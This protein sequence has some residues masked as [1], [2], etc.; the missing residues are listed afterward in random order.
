MRI[1]KVSLRDF[2]GFAGPEDYV[3]DLTDGKNLLLY[4]ENGSGKSSLYEALRGLFELRQP[5]TFQGERANVFTDVEDGYVSVEFSD[6]NPSEYRWDYKESAPGPSGGDQF[7]DIAR[8]AVFLDYRALLKTHYIHRD[9]ENINV[10]DLLVETLLSDVDFGDGVPLASHWKSLQ[11]LREDP[12]D[13]DPPSPDWDAFEG[14]RAGAKKF[15]DKL[16]ALLHT[17]TE[18]QLCLEAETNRLLGVLAPGLSISLVVGEHLTP[19]GREPL[20]M[21]TRFQGRAVLLKARYGGYEPEHAA[22]FLNEARLTAIALALCLAAARLN[23]PPA[24]NGNTL[25]L[26]VL[27]DVLIGLD[28]AHR[29]PLLKL[30]ARDFADWQVFVFTHDFTW[31]EMARQQVGPEG[32]FICELYCEQRDAEVFE[33][34]VLRQGG[35]EGF[36][37]RARVHLKAG[38]R[39]AAAVY[40]RAAFEEKLRKFC[41]DKSVPLPFKSNPGQV[42]GD[43]FLSA[44]EKRLR[45]Q[46]LWPFF[47]PQF[48]RLR[49]LRKVILNP[50][51]HS[52][53]VNLVSPE[54]HEA[55]EA[56]NEFMLEPPEARPGEKVARAALAAALKAALANAAQRTGFDP[57]AITDADAEMAIDLLDELDFDST[58]LK[59]ALVEARELTADEDNDANK[60]RLAA[61]LRAAFEDSLHRFAFRKKLKVPI[62]KTPEA[63]TTQELW[64][65]AKEHAHLQG[66]NS[67]QFRQDVEALPARAILL[68]ELNPTGIRA[69]PFNDLK[70]VF[71]L[72]EATQPLIETKFQ[73]KLDVFTK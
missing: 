45:E 56:V 58:K 38:E 21:L 61:C 34:P 59:P 27:D 1:T 42:D 17:P 63:L 65:I 10:F 8:R 49:M 28:L 29:L 55:I 50:M 70:A 40:A 22:H 37:K 7:L 2:R 25:R 36:L 32:W 73:T 16:D 18:H 67:V 41:D 5:K 19:Q 44:A 13:D 12:P 53:L 3:F 24:A 60:L 23:R 48:H 20:E 51:S 52:N 15:R 9:A 69:V 43:A 31:F 11:T 68:D 64:A 30:L 4:G 47:G 39:R 46:K 72:L 6:A 62:N 57:A 14:I 33:R 35:A 66:A 26:L 54:V 71:N